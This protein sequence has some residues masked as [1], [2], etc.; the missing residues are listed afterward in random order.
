MAYVILA[1]GQ[2]NI[3]LK[4]DYVWDD[5]PAN[6]KV[7]NY[8]DI[9]THVGTDF[10]SVGDK[11]SYAYSYAAEYAQN[12]PAEEVF[13]INIGNNGQPISKWLGGTTPNVYADCKNNVEAALSFIGKQCIDCLLWWQGESDA[14]LGLSHIY[15]SSFET[16]ISRFKGES[17]F[18][19]STKIIVTGVSSLY[20]NGSVQYFN[21]I[22]RA[23]VLTEPEFRSFVDTSALPIQYWSAPPPDYYI[24][25]NAEGY[26]LAGQMAY[27]CTTSGSN[28][29]A[30]SSTWQTIVKSYSTPVGTNVLADDPEMKFAVLPGKTYRAKFRLFF[31]IGGGAG[32]KWGLTGPAA[33][34][35]QSYHRSVD[36][37]TPTTTVTSSHFGSGY[38]TNQVLM[39]GVA[40]FLEIELFVYNPCAAGMIKLQWAKNTNVPGGGHL[41]LGSTV[42]VLEI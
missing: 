21:N 31:N 19:A 27:N 32:V 11:V 37:S 20:D 3:Q 5:L 39:S 17:W 38:V 18:K 29:A 30:N 41:F 26:R 10:V 22:L 25:M 15:R 14:Q 16:L 13:L 9:T 40:S 7:W 28:V 34:L 36:Q 2:S 8:D 6:L 35:I 12:H 23:C 1:T 24:H 33:T 42:D 4:R